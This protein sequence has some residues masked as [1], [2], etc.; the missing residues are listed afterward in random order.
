[1]R[2]GIVLA[3]GDATR[4]P[5]KAL[6]PLRNGLPM[7]TSAIELCVRNNCTGAP[8]MI[9]RPDSLILSVLH[10][11]QYNVCYREQI[12]PRGLIDA[13]RIATRS[14]V[15]GEE[16]LITFCDNYYDRNELIPATAKPPCVAVRDVKEGHGKD[17]GT[18]RGKTIAGW[19]LLDQSSL[20]TVSD[21]CLN[22]KLE[23]WL[24]TMDAQSIE[25]SSNLE[26]WD[27]GTKETYQNYWVQGRISSE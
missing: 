20:R 24:E 11:W 22:T 2:L 27:L 19:L 6:L 10:T 5:N 15:P 26:W 8:L 12:E 4:L 18:Y 17:L 23:D 9:V 1:M 14:C 13:I 7:I 3:G 16:Y 21:C 25:M